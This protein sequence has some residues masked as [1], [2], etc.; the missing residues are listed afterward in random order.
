MRNRVWRTATVAALGAV[1]GLW[2]SATPM[3]AHHAFTAEF[4]A[5]KPVTVRGIVTKV[6]WINPH[7]SMW[8]SR[9]LTGRSSTGHSSSARL[10]PCSGGAGARI[11]S[12]R[13]LK[14]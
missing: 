6:E 5:T 13:V 1:L 14:W 9:S 3:L 11:R 10:T 12:D 7:S 8:M 2:L 4:D